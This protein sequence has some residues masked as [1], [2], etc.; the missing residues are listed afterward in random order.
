MKTRLLKVLLIPL[1]LIVY[2]I[3]VRIIGF[4]IPCVFRLITGFKC[5]GCGVSRML[6]ALLKLDFQEAFLSN[7]LVFILLPLILFIIV[8]AAY[9]YVTQKKPGKTA[10]S[11][12][13]IVYPSL[14]AVLLIWGVLRNIWHM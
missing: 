1:I 2:Y 14:I 8:R 13:K 7:R 11:I 3:I 10:S 9:F 4:G 6:M 12:E 5:P